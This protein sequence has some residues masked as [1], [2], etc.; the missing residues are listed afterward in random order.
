MFFV[1]FITL[2][3]PKLNDVHA[4]VGISAMAFGYALAAQILRVRSDSDLT[5]L[6]FTVA[7]VIGAMTV[8]SQVVFRNYSY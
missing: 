4:T 1:G 5:D 6:D 7:M 3:Q 2:F 8:V